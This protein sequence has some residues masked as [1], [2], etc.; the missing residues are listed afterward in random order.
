MFRAITGAITETETTM[1]VSLYEASVLTYV[2]A[3]TGVTAFMNKGLAHFREHDIDPEEIV[4]TRVFP[5]ML[6]FRFQ[7]HQVVFH[8]LGAVEAIQKG[9]LHLPGDRPAHEYAGLQ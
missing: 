8:S 1:A 3:L 6:P 4:E 5:D 9:A 2:Q 7:I